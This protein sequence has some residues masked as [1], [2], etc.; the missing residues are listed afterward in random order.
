LPSKPYALYLRHCKPFML[1]AKNRAGGEA[2]YPLT[3]PVS[4]TANYYLP[5]FANWPDL[6][7]LMQATGDI[8][9][10]CGVI[11]NDRLI[12]D[13]QDTRIAGVDREYPRT[14]IKI[15]EAQI[16]ETMACGYCGRSRKEKPTENASEKI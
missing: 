16:S 8:L 1:A 11:S 13:W 14:E 5:R 2:R 10:S 3:V 6:V 4:V 15:Y 9:E 7:G 12:A